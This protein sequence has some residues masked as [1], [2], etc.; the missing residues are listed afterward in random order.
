MLS[1]HVS[2]VYKYCTGPI[3]TMEKAACNDTTKFQLVEFTICK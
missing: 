1:V 2:M 3:Y